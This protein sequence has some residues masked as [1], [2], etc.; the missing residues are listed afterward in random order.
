MTHSTADQRV[1]DDVEKYGWHCLKVGGEAPEFAYS[2]GLWKSMNMPE[3][4]MFGLPLDHSHAMLGNVVDVVRA[5][6]SIFDGARL[7]DVMNNFDVAVRSVHPSH[8]GDHFGFARWFKR[9]EGRSEDVEAFQVFWPDR[10]GRFPWE[11]D[12]DKY[13]DGMQPLLFEVKANA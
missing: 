6:A 13:F 7:A 3:I 2:V 11:A 12:F 5:G 9:I 8:I 1:I 4:I 10:E